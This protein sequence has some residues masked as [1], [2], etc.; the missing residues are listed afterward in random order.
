MMMS[1]VPNLSDYFKNSL[2]EVVEAWIAVA[3]LNDDGFAI[4]DQRLGEDVIQH[5]LIGIDLPTTVSALRIIQSRLSASKFEAKI[6]KR[7]NITYHP[8]VYLFRFADNTYDAIVGSA[9][10]T[11]GGFTK[12][13][14]FNV[15]I[16]EHDK[17]LDIQQWFEELYSDAFPVDDEN[18]KR[19]E[20][21]WQDYRPSSSALGKMQQLKL[22][23]PVEITDALSGID[24]TD[25]YF[26]AE[27]HRAFRLDFWYDYDKS[28]ND[29][30]KA[31]ADVFVELHRQIY[32]QFYQYSL[33][34]LRPNT[35]QH[36]VS[37]HYHDPS[38]SKQALN[39]MWL[40]YGKSEEEIKLYHKE[41]RQPRLRGDDP[42]DDKQ[43]FINHAR[44]QIRIEFKEIGIWILFAKNN[45]GGVVDR[46][47][48]KER[49]R[50]EPTYRLDF[51]KLLTG[52]PEPYFIKVN[53]DRKDV[54][55][56]T[57]EDMLY[58]YCRK[59]HE[60]A[61]FTI[62]RDYNITD[63]EMS[64]TLLPLEVLQVFSLLYPLYRHMR[65][66]II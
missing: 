59:D 34:K 10:M 6:F 39:A 14:E 24:F 41:Y 37:M 36:L 17:C 43:S 61:Y 42:E 27:H 22:Q 57:D 40:S 64:A 7:T 50:T 20:Q 45:G 63:P 56:F 60:D 66:Y 47:V 21:R 19:Y 29:A 30:R 31:V 44:L 58:R 5:Y 16:E 54:G 62:G 48:F 9:N 53:D 11:L 23:K 12:N 51:F 25:R 3:L 1:L 55:F 32:Q 2:S 65:H 35:P 49:M 28:A 46:N 15:L 8:K 13:I 26:K 52:L 33:Q 18:I 4:L 38:K